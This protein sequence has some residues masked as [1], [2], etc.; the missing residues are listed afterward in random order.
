[1]QE[2][3]LTLIS[4]HWDYFTEMT[5]FFCVINWNIKVIRK[6]KTLVMFKCTPRY[7]KHPQSYYSFDYPLIFFFP[8]LLRSWFRSTHLPK[9]NRLTNQLRDSPSHDAGVTQRHAQQVP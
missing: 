6:T 5:I 4:I 7:Q 8:L 9:L 1:M 3:S 2:K